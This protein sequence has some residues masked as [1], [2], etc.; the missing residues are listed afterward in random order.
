[1][2]YPGASWFSSTEHGRSRRTK[3]LIKENIPG[4]GPDLFLM[5]ELT[6][7]AT[8]TNH[9]SPD[10]P[11]TLKGALAFIPSPDRPPKFYLTLCFLLLC[12]YAYRLSKCCHHQLD[13]FRRL[14]AAFPAECLKANS[15]FLFSV[16]VDLDWF[17]LTS[18]WRSFQ[19]TDF[20]HQIM[21]VFLKLWFSGRIKCVSWANDSL[22][23]KSCPVE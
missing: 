6:S 12:I 23:L 14:S 11:P 22:F 4:Q 19:A 5:K 9:A 8:K 10:P 18:L 15:S 21:N 16:G 3:R 20:A 13:F 7:T 17:N 2:V 1:M